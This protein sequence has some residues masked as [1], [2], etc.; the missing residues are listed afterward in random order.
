MPF[1]LDRIRTAASEASPS[2]A[3]VGQWIV[4]HPIQAISRS[5]EEIADLTGTSVAAI[6]RFSRAAG[7]DGFGHLK[8]V[9]GEE[10]QSAV[11]PVRKLDAG[12]AKRS[13]P[14]VDSA[15][16][17]AAGSSPEVQRAAGRLLKA[18]QVWLLGMGASSHL[19]G[20]AVHALMPYL[21]RVDTVAGEGGTEEAA[22]RLARC[23]PGDLLV[24]ISL[25]RYSRDTVLLTRFAR[26]RGARVIAIT[27]ARTA[28]IATLCDTLLLAPS[29][30]DVMPSSALGALAVIESLAAAVM[31]LNPDAV[32]IANELS[33][34][35]LSHLAPPSP[36][37]SR[38]KEQ[39]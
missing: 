20:Y 39:P 13:R 6:N 4:G 15:A 37:T 24:A 10:L 38:K 34:A 9:L 32:R 31:R 26:E 27:D 17:H 3:R 7:F 33:E 22:R 30:H 11:D 23:G 5:A 21:P 8:E 12:A 1:A 29:E 19:A 28:P 35:V 2:L 16:L 36:P 14:T 25:P 18:H